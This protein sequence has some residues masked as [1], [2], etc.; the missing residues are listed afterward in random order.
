LAIADD[1]EACTATSL[2]IP[3]LEPSEFD[4]KFPCNLVEGNNEPNS[5]F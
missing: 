1:N 2:A 3:G 4:E 5:L